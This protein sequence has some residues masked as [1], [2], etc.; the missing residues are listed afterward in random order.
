MSE[1]KD[2]LPKEPASSA[3]A[4]PRETLRA[5]GPANTGTSGY[6]D[7]PTH[8]ARDR[9]FTSRGTSAIITVMS[10]AAEK[11]GRKLLRD[12][13]EVE[14][15]QVSKKGPADFVS[16][17]DLTAEKI[18]MEELSRARPEVGF[19]AEESG[20]TPA[21]GNSNK[22][23]EAAYET[24]WVID[25]LDGTTNYLH[26]LP[27]WAISIALEEK[28]EITAALVYDP[29]KQEMFHA[30]KGEGA[31][32]NKKRLRVSGRLDIT[33]C[34]FGTGA[35]FK[36][37][38]D[39][40]QFQKELAEILPLGSGVRRF[41][42]A[43]LDLAYIAAGRLDGFWERDLSPWDVA[44]GLLLVREAGGMVTQIDGK[45]FNIHDN[46]I[47]AA[48]PDIHDQMLRALKVG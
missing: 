20:E 42:A 1:S 21:E 8:L 29:V 35:P 6:R 5:R 9:R 19:L 10:D 46:S 36:G 38:G 34:L 22:K 48:A 12:F 4:K 2:P 43:A 3:S 40:D 27:H 16:K 37:H 41:G 44:A 7:E 30:E 24:R 26:G 32:M 47:L 45:K 33:A 15:L 39:P 23:S 17:A 13:G 14:R 31:F 25:P 28:G 18:L 11:A